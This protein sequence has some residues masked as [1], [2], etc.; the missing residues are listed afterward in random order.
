MRSLIICSLLFLTTMPGLRADETQQ[1]K[2]PPTTSTG[3]SS[4]RVAAEDV[5]DIAVQDH[6]DLSK[7]TVV[8]PDG[9]ISY[10][11]AGEFKASGL[12]LHE[13]ADRITGA[14]RKEIAGPQVT[15]TIKS[16]HERPASQVSI[17]GAVHT[18]GKHNLK[19]GWRILDLLIEAGGLA[20]DHPIGFTA[21]MVRNGAEIIPV[22]LARVMSGTDAKANL[23]LLPGDILVV[24]E[25]VQAAVQIQIMGEVA[26]P[27]AFGIPANASIVTVLSAAGGPTPRAALSK[28]VITHN[29]Q[30]R[31]V[32]LSGFLT[33]GKVSENVKLETGDTLFIPENRLSYSVY[34]AVAHTGLQVYPD[35]QKISA[36]TALSLA[37]G[38]GPGANLKA[39]SVIHPS[40]D[41]KPDIKT[42]N[43][44]DVIKKGDISKDVALQPGDIL[45]IPSHKS[46]PSF[47]GFLSALPIIGFLGLRH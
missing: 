45:Y 14:L 28:T 37:G 19:E 32:D 10:P 29:G 42:I 20:G 3:I 24:R 36:L 18:A 41:G 7:T 11:Y 46:G 6:P 30:T 47:A 38:Q 1:P 35:N 22:D 40:K 39:V 9:T 15:V 13:I 2:T 44:E 21:S 4:Y 8:L 12:T 25:V 5:L 43:L 16:L 23:L 31:T 27:G 34:G 17:L 26:H 33:E